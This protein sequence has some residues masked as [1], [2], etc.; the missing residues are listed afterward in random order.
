MLLSS[1]V[2]VT[3]DPAALGVR[4]GNDARPRSPQVFGLALELVERR[5]ELGVEQDIAEG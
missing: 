1:I 4:G 3:F 2:K 5:L